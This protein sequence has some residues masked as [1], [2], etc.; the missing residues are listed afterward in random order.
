[1][2][3]V[4]IY[5]SAL[6]SA[7]LLCLAPAVLAAPTPSSPLTVTETER[8]VQQQPAD[9]DQDGSSGHAGAASSVWYG[10]LDAGPR[11][12]RFVIQQFDAGAGTLLYRLV[13]LDE[14]GQKFVLSPFVLSEAELNFEL[15]A[16]RAI[17]AG[18]RSAEGNSVAGTWKQ[19]GQE[20]PLE[21]QRLAEAP[22]DKPD[23]VWNGQLNAVIQKLELQIRIYQAAD[24][25]ES[26]YLDSISQKA[27]GFKASR[28][29]TGTEWRLDIP[30]LKASFQGTLSD[31]GQ[32]LEGTFTQ[33]L[34]PLALVLERQQHPVP[35]LMADPKRPQTPVPPFPYE[36]ELVQFDNKADGLHI[37]GTLTI[38]KSGKPVPAVVLISGSGPQDR[39]ETIANHKPFHV[40]ADHLSRNGIAVLRCD[41]RGVGGSSGEFE[42]ATT[43][44]FARDVEAA[45]DFLLADQRIDN[46]RIG[47][48]GHS[49]GGLIAPIVGSRRQDVAF[50]VLLAGP[51]VNGRE[52]L[53]SQGQLILKAAGV[54][55]EQTL[56]GQ[57]QSQIL[58]I[59]AVQNASVDQDDA[60]LAEG[61]LQALREQVPQ[62]TIDDETLQAA[63]VGNIQKL[64]S[65]WFQFFLKHEP[66]PVL[67]KVECPVL[68]LNGSHDVQVDP[69]LNLPRIA[70]AFQRSGN[71][72]GETREL[73]QL[74]HL[75]QTSRTGALQ[76]YGEIEETFA[77]S[78]M[79]IITDWIHG[80]CDVQ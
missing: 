18:K 70:E 61:V 35:A 19:S 62:G 15:K 33:N 73:S 54:T 41:D 3:C 22:V 37:A 24:G 58:M 60:Q 67:E 76:E 78:A 65:P 38:P 21:F 6:S 11:V 51:G 48:I 12:F 16:S 57:L 75:F 23:E 50:L 40:L 28:T 59:D 71:D 10:K 14:G 5:L 68:A 49:E 45:V 56:A 80:V 72:R 69:K 47:L 36:I 34:I 77:P 20:F 2:C 30:M 4:Q 63:V 8:G 53:V 52:I 39:D 26:V 25:M 44:D 13:S 55:D 29:I 27:G 66:L 43:E 32:T 74:N 79:A 7:I 64:R 42:K 17:Y 31:D 1:M 9:T 46:A